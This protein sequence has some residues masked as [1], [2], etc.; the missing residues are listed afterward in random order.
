MMSSLVPEEVVPP[1][2]STPRAATVPILEAK[3]ASLLR[4]RP[5]SSRLRTVFAVAKPM[6]LTARPAKRSTA[7]VVLAARVSVVFDWTGICVSLPVP[8]SAS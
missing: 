7:E 4:R 2:V 6:L 1:A 3:P 8:K 5:P